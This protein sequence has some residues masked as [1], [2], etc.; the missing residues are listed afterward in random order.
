MGI[1]DQARRFSVVAGDMEIHQPFRREALQELM[2]VVTVIDAV[3]IEVVDVQVQAAVGLFQ[4]R[5]N[6]GEFVH[7]R[8]S[9]GG[10]IGGVFHGNAAFED[11][12][13]P[14]DAGGHV[15][16][17]FPGEGERQQF[18]EMSFVVAVTQVLGVE[19]DPMFIQKGFDPSEKAFVQGRG[20][21]QGQRQAVGDE[22]VAFGEFPELPRGTAAQADPVFRGDLE[23]VNGRGLSGLQRE[24]QLP[25][26]AQ[27]R[28][29]D[30][31]GVHGRLWF[32]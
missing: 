19:A 22:R 20:S 23:K 13:G 7:F 28:P 11:F 21:T 3:H 24:H 5:A 26:E 2:G 4:H 27:A 18:V 8:H 16:D 30:A 14:A 9:G 6:E 25:P 29:V 12:L 31:R 1:H 10:V 32:R 15:A 17:G